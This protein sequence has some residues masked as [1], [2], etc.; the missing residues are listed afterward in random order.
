MTTMATAASTPP[1]PSY[2][3]PTWQHVEWWGGSRHVTSRG[4]VFF[5]FTINVL[6]YASNVFL[7]PNRHMNG[8]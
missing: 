5:F 2:T 7:G 6:F 3:H 4:R 1:H 8:Q